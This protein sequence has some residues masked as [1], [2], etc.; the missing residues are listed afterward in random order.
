VRGTIGLLSLLSE[1]LD[2]VPQVPVLAAGG[3][4]TGRAMTAAL[5]AGTDGVRLGTRFV[6]AE[7]AGVHPTYVQALVARHTHDTV[8]TRT[9]HVGWPEAPHRV[10][11][12]AIEAAEAFPD[13][14]VGKVVWLDGTEVAVPR[15]G[16]RVPDRTVTGEVA[17]MS[18]YAGES[19]GAV[20]RVLPA[21]EVIRELV[22][23]AEQLLR[24]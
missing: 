12:S 24:H 4:G 1:V 20:K 14:I 8:Y 3:I 6:A 9:F 19:V 11:R 15:F 21:R 10:P 2:A 16:T 13:E 23:E 22:E 7:E 5:A 18:L 17:T